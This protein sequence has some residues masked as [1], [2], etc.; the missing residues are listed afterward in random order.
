MENT[1]LQLIRGLRK[2][3]KPNY[4]LMT[5]QE[6]ISYINTFLEGLSNT[7]KLLE[8]LRKSTYSASQLSYQEN[9][10]K[11]KP[12]S[13]KT[14]EGIV[15]YHPKSDTYT[16]E[17]DQVLSKLIGDPSQPTKL[18]KKLGNRFYKF[19][20]FSFRVETDIIT[21]KNIGLNTKLKNREIKSKLKGEE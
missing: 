17:P 13:F 1:F 20:E 15:S 3:E 5:K 16:F 21:V 14:S 2:Q 6:L 19:L 10:K 9:Y 11:N 7:E 12:F 18:K 4:D 8:I